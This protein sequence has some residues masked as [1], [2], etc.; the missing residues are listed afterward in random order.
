MSK[1]YFVVRDLTSA[2]ADCV[3]VATG[4]IPGTSGALEGGSPTAGSYSLFKTPES[5]NPPVGASV[6][7][8]DA[9][10]AGLAAQ[11]SLFQGTPSTTFIRY[12][13]ELCSEIRAR[14]MAAQSG[15][16]LAAAEAMLAVLEQTSIALSAGSPTLGYIR[17]NASALDQASKD[18]FNPLFERHFLRFPRDFT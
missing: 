8:L 1:R 2:D 13:F 9:E 14:F 16:P 3:E 6:V 17:F 15:L 12:E 5:C 7:E 18:A 11:T 4:T 10:E